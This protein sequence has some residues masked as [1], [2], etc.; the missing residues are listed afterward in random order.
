MISADN[1]IDTFHQIV[2]SVLGAKTD[3]TP[4][5]HVRRNEQGHKPVRTR[6]EGLSFQ[7]EKV[8]QNRKLARFGN[9]PR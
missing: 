1:L 2:C 6:K 8:R 9:K 3:K 7:S 5:F 4:L